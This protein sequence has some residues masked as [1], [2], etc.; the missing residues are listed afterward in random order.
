[1]ENT[2]T[3]SSYKKVFKEIDN[4]FKIQILKLLENP[5]CQFASFEKVFKERDAMKTLYRK[6]AK[7][8]LSRKDYWSLGEIFGDIEE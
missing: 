5:F 6:W 1:M 2:T 4:N 7:D 3:K 8:R